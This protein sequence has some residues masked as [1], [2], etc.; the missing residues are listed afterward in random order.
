MQRT[1]RTSDTERRRHPG[2][3]LH[4]TQHLI[5]EQVRLAHT[6]TGP[7]GPSIH[8][9]GEADE[10]LRKFLR[11]WRAGRRDAKGGVCRPGSEDMVAQ[12]NTEGGESCD[13]GNES[14]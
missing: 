9:N 8:L 5:H 10:A 13:G 14:H 11:K 3:R 2:K 1:R 7:R 12:Q 4:Y 6:L